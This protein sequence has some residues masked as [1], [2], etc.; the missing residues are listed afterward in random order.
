MK[1]LVL[2]G[3]RFFGIHMVNNL[4]TRGHQVTIATRGNKVDDFGSKVER[5]IIERTDFNSMKNSF[6]D[7][8]YDVVCDNLAYCS[9]D[10]KYALETIDCKR[11]VMVS[12][13]SVYDLHIDTREESYNPHEKEMIWCDRT[14]FEY[15]E[16]KRLAE[17]AL[18][19]FYTTKE[20][21]AVRF[22]FV[23]GKDDYTNRLLF[24]VEHIVKEKP[25]FIDNVNK[26]MG[27]ISSDYAGKFLSFLVE[28]DY[29]GSI[30]GSCNG[31]ISLREMIDYIERRT[32]KKAILDSNGEIAPYNGVDDYSLNTYRASQ[33]GFC[34]SDLSDCIYDLINYYIDIL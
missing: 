10:V 33:L 8:R 23:I 13:A 11:Y 26:Q 22:P 24:Y 12:S 14:E 25:M 16:I 3:T 31:T 21:L 7:K 4:L 32:N 34:F 29:C 28:S 6:K 1:V 5:I 17:C 27:F 30:N 20:S 2:G 18:V 9:N 19:K 15:D